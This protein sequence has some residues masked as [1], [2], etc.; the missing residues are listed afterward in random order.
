MSHILE[1]RNEDIFFQSQYNL[2]S[3]PQQWEKNFPVLQ[4][5]NSIKGSPNPACPREG[6]DWPLQHNTSCPQA[7]L[8]STTHNQGFWWSTQ[9]WY[10]PL[11]H[12]KRLTHTCRLTNSF[13]G[14][15]MHTPK[16]M[17]A[18]ENYMCTG[19]L[20]ESEE[21]VHRLRRMVKVHSSM[22]WRPG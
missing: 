11:P 6:S 18:H 20:T 7:C 16:C 8:H 22:N 15:S 13:E 2:P 5:Y 1:K 21:K 9:R 10:I 4:T 14:P 12:T 17:W 3:F 19:L